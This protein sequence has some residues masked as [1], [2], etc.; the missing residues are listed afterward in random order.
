MT[1][2]LSLRGIRLAYLPNNQIKPPEKIGHKIAEIQREWEHGRIDNK[3]RSGPE[4]NRAA[5]DHPSHRR[6]ERN[7]AVDRRVIESSQSRRR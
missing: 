5:K 1:P 2:L 3:E 4:S 6:S 7:R